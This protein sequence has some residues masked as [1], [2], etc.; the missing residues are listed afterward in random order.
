MLFL[1][2][3]VIYD[4]AHHRDIEGFGGLAAVM[5]ST[6]ESARSRSSRRWGCPDCRLHLGSAG[7]ARHVAEVPRAHR[8][9]RDRVILTAGYLLWTVQRVYLGV[10]NE[11][12]KLM[13]DINAREL[14]TMIPLGIIVIIV[15][16]YPTVVL[17]LLRAT[18]TQLNQVIVPHLS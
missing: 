1:M 5:P 13:P 2:V 15:G 9:G 4:R 18:L 6:R 8:I 11:K 14:F 10:T 16:V 17:D 3:G 12:Y 7:A